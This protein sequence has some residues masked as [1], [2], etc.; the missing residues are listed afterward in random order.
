LLEPPRQ[1]WYWA[2]QIEKETAIL[3]TKIGTKLVF[4]WA[5]ALFLS[6][7]WLSLMEKPL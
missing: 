1:E 2:S 6:H 5:M 3:P 4:C 7:R